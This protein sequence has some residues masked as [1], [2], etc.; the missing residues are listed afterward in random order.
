VVI[1]AASAV[2]CDPAGR[3][4]LVLRGHAP[5]QGLWSLPGGSVEAGE[6][7]QEA[8]TREVREETGLVVRAGEEVWQVTVPLAPGQFYD[9]RAVWAMVE[10][11]VLAA[12][13][14]AAA[15]AWVGHDELD[16]LPLTPHLREFL[17]RFRPPGS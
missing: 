8:A 6:S 1:R 14:D 5:A 7:L 15:V 9:V 2:I 16:S 10:G 17:G 12:G 13:D 11:G 4:L 3:F